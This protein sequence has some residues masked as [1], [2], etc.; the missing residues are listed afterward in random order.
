MG[1]MTDNIMK[2]WG[3][4]K[5]LQDK[6]QQKGEVKAQINYTYNYDTLPVLNE[7]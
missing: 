4:V 6:L 2:E 7:S 1:I 3:A 5:S